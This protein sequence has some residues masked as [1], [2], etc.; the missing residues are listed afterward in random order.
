MASKMNRACTLKVG[1]IEK[2]PILALGMSEK[3][4]EKY[5]RVAKAYGN[6]APAIV[7]QS[8][9]AYRILAGQ[10]R[11]EACARNGIREIPA[12]VAETG[13]EVERL[14]LALLLSTVREE[15]GPLSEGALIDALTTRHGV[16]RRE[17]MALLKKSKSWVS[18]RH[19]LALKL[20]E[21]VK[22]MVRDGSICAR[23]AE[24]IAK[25]PNDVQIPF[26]SKVVMD[27]L[28]KTNAE[29]LVSMYVAEDAGDA[30]RE[31]ILAT[32][33]A[34]LDAADDIRVHR[35]KE[36]RGLAERIASTARFLIRMAC[37][38]K[39]L[40]ATTDSQETAAASPDLS[41]LRDALVDLHTILGLHAGVSPGKPQGGGAV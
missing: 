38:L 29:R 22:G 25:L 7:G 3:D 34:V 5:G 18:K 10:A 37:E 39:G 28:S 12:I 1:E 2:D 13:G 35:Q 23:T 20:S 9:N 16:S 19:S 17:L 32:P 4:I 40:L 24:E 33:L 8:G 15:G 36:K 41:A 26:A 27:G 21:D 6:V 11:L 30:L 14:K 31:S